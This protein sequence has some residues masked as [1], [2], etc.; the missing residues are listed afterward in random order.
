MNATPRLLRLSSAT[1]LLLALSAPRPAIAQEPAADTAATPTGAAAPEPAGVPVE[2]AE[3]DTAA[4]ADGAPEAARPSSP[5]PD[6]GGEYLYD[7]A[8]SDDV[9]AAIDRATEDAGFFVRRIGRGKL[10]DRLRPEG[11]IVLVVT[12]STAAIAEGDRERVE[13]PLL[14]PD[15]AAEVDRSEPWTTWDGEAL[16]RV[17]PED[18]GLRTYRYMLDPDGDTLRVQVRVEG[19]KLPE[20]VE[21][22]LTYRRAGAADGV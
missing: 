8:A 9:R 15:E 3:P 12:D 1:L 16:T 22:T 2:D 20:P 18:E 5:T 6:L 19:G 21:Y 10:E 14:T 17:V 11:R 7:E 13:T 4:E